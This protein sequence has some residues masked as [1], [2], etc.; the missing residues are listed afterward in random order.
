M[1]YV[2]CKPVA[3]GDRMTWTTY[4][5]LKHIGEPRIIV[6][7]RKKNGLKKNHTAQLTPFNIT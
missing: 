1:Q 5:F 4:F 3:M 6:F 2:N 7:R